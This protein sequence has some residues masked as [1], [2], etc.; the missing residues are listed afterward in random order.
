MVVLSPKISIEYRDSSILVT[1]HFSV[2]GNTLFN[3]N[4]IY[5]FDVCSRGFLIGVRNSLHIA[6]ISRI[7]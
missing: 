4:G 3:N 6:A 2:G 1:H 5:F 7:D